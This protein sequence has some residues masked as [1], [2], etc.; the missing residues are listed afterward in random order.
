M[1]FNRDYHAG[2]NNDP[3]HGNMY[4][5]SYALGQLE[6]QAEQ[7]RLAGGQGSN[8][9]ALQILIVGV[10]LG[11]AAYGVHGMGWLVLPFWVWFPIWAVVTHLAFGGLERLPGVVSGTLMGLLMGAIAA[12]IT[13]FELDLWWTAGTGLGTAVIGYLLFHRLN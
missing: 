2:R 11:A 10:L 8:Q 1:E 4:S 12:T 3:L 6:R 7:D 9:H 13:S 5:T